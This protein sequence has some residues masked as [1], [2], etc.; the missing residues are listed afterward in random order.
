[1]SSA[2][3]DNLTFS[4]AIWMTFI[5]P[6][7]SIALSRTVRTVLNGNRES[8]HPGLAP[9]FTGKLS[10]FTAEYGLA[11]ICT[12]AFYQ[13]WEDAFIYNLLSVSIMKRC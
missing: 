1:M 4:F 12:D 13:V 8:G 10:V 7:C 2:N 5:S 11:M 3:R 9:D 6:S